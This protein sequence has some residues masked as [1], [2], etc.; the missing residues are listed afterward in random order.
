MRNLVGSSWS[1]LGAAVVGMAP[2]L[3]ACSGQVGDAGDENGPLGTARLASGFYIDPESSFLVRDVAVV[4]DVTRTQD[5]CLSTSSADAN[6]RWTFGYLMSQMASGVS[7]SS[8]ARSWL[9]AWENSTTV[10]GDPLVEVTPDP[11]SG[12]SNSKPLARL[13]REAWE[14]ASG[15]TTLA[16]NKAPFR[17]LA[18]VNRFDLRKSP[19]NFGEGASGELRFVFS[20]LDLDRRDDNDGACSQYPAIQNLGAG[21]QGEQLVI[22][23][24]AVDKATA[25]AKKDWALGWT[26]LT[27]D[28][29]EEADP[30]NRERGT[31]RYKQ[32]LEGLTEQ[33]VVKG[34]GGSRPNGSALIRI[35]TNET[36]NDIGWDLRE[37]QIN[38]STHLVVPVTVKQTPRGSLNGSNDLALWM[39]RNSSAILAGTY[40][41][42]NTFPS[43]QGY[44]NTNFLGSHSLLQHSQTFWT[45]GSRY[46]VGSDV[47]H[48]FSK[49]TCA[50]CHS[51]ET[52]SL[53]FH[54]HG[55]RR[56]DSSQI[57]QFLEGDGQGGEYCVPDPV[58]PSTQRCFN[59][60]N[61]RVN[62]TLSFLN[63]GI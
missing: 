4:E 14:R 46:S 20:V 45:G 17:L 42:P 43:R 31:E 28:F 16:M 40:V 44:S 23:E 12:A 29:S 7:P 19:R 5:P 3:F 10:N 60:L 35:R 36:A 21:E 55:R 11:G 18:I 9:A 32:Q 2:V 33:V 47:R 63:S 34:N 48:A 62:D 24:Y 49:N 22:L 8:F 61:R 15:G 1:S 50:G 59:E 26:A 6:K 51:R 39:Q 52:G 25:Q 57:S 30:L 13:I 58:V 37:F 38:A 54:V 41:V 56:G 53:F 27:T